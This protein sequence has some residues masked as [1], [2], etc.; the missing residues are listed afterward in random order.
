MK[1]LLS[2]CAKAINGKL[3]GDDV[4]FRSVSIDTRAIKPE[5]LYIAIKGQNF[6]GNEFVEQAQ[7]AGAV[8]AILHEGI[9]T[10]LPHVYVEDTRLA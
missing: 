4:L 3:V 2:D 10:S 5:Q 7:Q 8:A 9:N 1:M 6:D